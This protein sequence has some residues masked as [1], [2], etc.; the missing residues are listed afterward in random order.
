VRIALAIGV[1]VLLGVM[2]PRQAEAQSAAVRQLLRAGDE[3]YGHQDYRTAAAYYDRA[4]AVEPRGV[5]RGVYAKRASIYLIERRYARGLRWVVEVAERAFPD[6]VL[7]LRQ[8]VILLAKQGRGAEAVALAE[9]VVARDPGAY[10]LQFLIGNHHLG[11]GAAG[12]R[13]AVV[14]FA[15]YLRSRPAELAGA[16]GGVRLKLGY[17]YLM[18]RRYREA[19]EALGAAA[20]SGDRGVRLAAQRGRCAAE[21]GLR[22]WRRAIEVCEA[23]GGAGGGAGARAAVAGDAASEYNL[24][25]AYLAVGRSGDA[26]AAAGRY[27]RRRPRE[28]AAWLLRGE[29][30]LERRA[31]KEAREQFAQAR[32]LA[33]GDRAVAARAASGMGRAFLRQSPPQA[34]A[35]IEELAAAHRARPGDAAVVQDLAQ[36]HLLVGEIDEAIALAE[37]GVAAAADA[38]VRK[39]AMLALLGDAYQASAVGSGAAAPSGMADRLGR[40]LERYQQALVADPG[41]AAARAGAVAALVRMAAAA[42]EGGDMARAEALLGEALLRDPRAPMTNYDLAALYAITGRPQQAL[43]RVAITLAAVPRHA[44]AVRLRA[45]GRAALGDLAGALEDYRVADA[46]ASEGRDQ[47]LLAAIS[48]ERGAVLVGLGQVDEG[49]AALERG[50]ALATAIDPADE[51]LPAIRANL[52][53]AHAR[54]GLARLAGGDA[55]RAIADLEEAVRE[56]GLSTAEELVPLRFALAV[57]YLS[58]GRAGKGKAL[59]EEVAEAVARSGGDAPWLGETFRRGGVELYLGYAYLLEGDPVSL[60]S[61][62]QR[63]KKVVGRARGELRARGREVLRA[64]YEAQALQQFR[65]RDLA[66]AEVSLGEARKLAE[67]GAGAAAA[68]VA[69][70]DHNLG[71]VRIERRHERRGAAARRTFEAFGDRPPEALVN[72]GI[73]YDDEGDGRRAVEMWREAASRGVHGREIG[74]WIERKQRFWGEGKD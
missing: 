58:G 59:L 4:I 9:R 49:L 22:A 12:A 40:A 55:E 72:V 68:V 39:A 18:E 57:A 71:V 66:D 23:A 30:L 14:A 38:P 5:D 69:V 60:R 65:R 54:R 15:A 46:A 34:A 47:A 41:N 32:K 44:G 35:A 33:P 11:R 64:A 17:G 45:A 61:G 52:Q 48:A 6:D 3:A 1:A 37:A 19:A 31:Y 67:G 16:D 26:L 53:V 74:E 56:P 25:R 29:V 8:K 24:A 63:L 28:A 62:I 50:R 73:C 7:I 13:R 43:D 20:R 2:L 27:L 21:V 10:T 70:I 42:M 51:A 36:A